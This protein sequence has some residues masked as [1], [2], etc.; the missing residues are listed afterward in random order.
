MGKRV[1]A[2]L[3]IFF[4][5]TAAW[6]ILGATIFAR[7]YSADGSLRGV[8]IQRGGAAGAATAGGLLDR[9][10]HEEGRQR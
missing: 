2:I 5:T 4:C 10:D 9:A 6:G 7:T 8:S 3:F 1:A